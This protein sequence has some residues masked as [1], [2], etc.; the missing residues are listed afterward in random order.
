MIPFQPRAKN[1]LKGKVDVRSIISNFSNRAKS[2]EIMRFN[3]VEDSCS[4]RI[5]PIRFAALDVK[6]N[7]N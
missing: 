6:E 1:S 7:A 2:G 3:H 5:R 4:S